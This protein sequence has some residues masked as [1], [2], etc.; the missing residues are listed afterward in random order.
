MKIVIDIK[1]QTFTGRLKKFFSIQK[2]IKK[3]LKE[4]EKVEELLEV[5]NKELKK[6]KAQV[7]HYKRIYSGLEELKTLDS[8]TNGQK[9]PKALSIYRKQIKHL[10]SLAEA[11]NEHLEQTVFSNEVLQLHQPR[12]TK[13]LNPVRFF[14]NFKKYQEEKQEY[15]EVVKKAQSAEINFT[16][17]KEKN[18]VVVAANGTRHYKPENMLVKGSY[19][20]TDD[21]YISTYY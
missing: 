15:K 5:Q 17:A 6:I 4:R 21:K 19:L 13:S 16:L 9:V 3:S 12:F 14:K 7:K 11:H 18:W 1:P 10:S 20:Q 2:A 8:Y